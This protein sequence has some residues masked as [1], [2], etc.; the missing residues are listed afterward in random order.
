MPIAAQKLCSWKSCGS[1][2]TQHVRF[3]YRVLGSRDTPAP[4]ENYTILHRSLCDV[5]V[6]NIR[7]SYLDV[8]VYPIGQCPACDGTSAAGIG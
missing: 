3:G 2:A 1:S 6:E 5:H 8:T 4:G 7:D